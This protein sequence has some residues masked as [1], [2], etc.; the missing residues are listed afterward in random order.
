RHPRRVRRRRPL[1]RLA[2]AELPPPD[3]PGPHAA[4]FRPA[5]FLE[6]PLDGR[7]HLLR[8]PPRRTQPRKLPGEFL[9][10]RGAAA[11][12]LFPARSY[13]RGNAG[14]RG[15]GEPRF[16]LHAGLADDPIELMADRLTANPLHG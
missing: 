14:P 10:G 13:R 15:F 8:G 4:G 16:S 5:G 11:G 7:L 12:P 6:R 1:P 2:T 3:D 9:R